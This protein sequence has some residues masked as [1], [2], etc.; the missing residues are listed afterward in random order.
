VR[1]VAMPDGGLSR[2]RVIATPDAAGRRALGLAWWNTLPAAQLSGILTAAG[3]PAPEADGLVRRRP[4][5]DSAVLPGSAP[6]SPA[7][8]GVLSETSAA[9]VNG[10]LFGR[11]G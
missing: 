5:T 2:L 10:L 8:P 9:V 1:L 3:V 11:A 4:L 7:D 6:R